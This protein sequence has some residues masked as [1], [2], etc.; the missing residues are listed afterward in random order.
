[1]KKFLLSALTLISILVL[2]ACSESEGSEEEEVPKE[3]EGTTEEKEAAIP[4]ST[5]NKISREIFGDALIDTEYYE[6]SNHVN[7]Y[8]NLNN[9]SDGLT[10]NMIKTEA[11]SDVT[12]L[13][14]ALQNEYAFDDV[15]VEFE[16]TLVNHYEERKD[17]VIAIDFEKE[18]IERVDSDNFLSP[19]IP[20]EADHYWEHPLFSE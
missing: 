14:I 6:A 19:D 7:I 9:L 2:G 13:L 20:N 16:T 3:S 8:V 18:T 5:A 11:Y 1:M 4:E 10:N 15:Y 12:N 17:K